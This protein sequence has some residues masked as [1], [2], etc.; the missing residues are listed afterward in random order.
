MGDLSYLMDKAM[1]RGDI[2]LPADFLVL[3]QRS[4][5][6][7]FRPKRR[8]ENPFVATSD[9]DLLTI[10]S[11]CNKLGIELV[12]RFLAVRLYG[13]P[14]HLA[15]YQDIL[16]WVTTCDAEQQSQAIEGFSSGKL[17]D[18]QVKLRSAG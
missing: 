16:Q 15:V 5:R 7:S 17:R 18:I 13:Y 8:R 11:I 2:E 3:S 12:D 9:E 10:K 4:N 1:E 6:N 14:S